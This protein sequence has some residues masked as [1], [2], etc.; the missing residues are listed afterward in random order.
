MTQCYED[1]SKKSKLKL[2]ITN[3]SLLIL[4]TMLLSACGYKPSSQLIKKTFNE[5]IYVQVVVDRVEPENAAF[6]KDEMN[7]LVYTR[8][9]GRV[10]SKEQATN[11]IRISYSGTTFSPLTY[12][13]G[14]VSR[15]QVNVRVNY[16]MVTK[17]GTINKTISTIFES[18][19]QNA[20]IDT[21]VIKTEAIREGLVK[22]MD[23]FMAYISAKSANLE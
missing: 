5:N 23:E 11:S 12:K 10:V 1:F 13:D 18:T 17:Q 21:S 20:S 16:V 2:L 9:K 22:S 4:A 3:Y 19:I 7:R 8:F 6:V 15:Y 14:Y